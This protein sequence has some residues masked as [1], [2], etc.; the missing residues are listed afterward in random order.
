MKE[1]LYVSTDGYNRVFLVSDGIK[2][3]LKIDIKHSLK[4]INLGIKAFQKCRNKQ[5]GDKIVYRIS[6]EGLHALFPLF[7]KRKLRISQATFLYLTF[8]TNIKLE[9]LPSD[10]AELRSIASDTSLGY[11]ILY[12]EHD[13]IVLEMCT[14]LKFTSSIYFMASDDMITGLRIKYCDVYADTFKAKDSVDVDDMDK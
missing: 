2:E 6:Q 9:S 5:N 12:V 10:N 7:S 14:M 8:N 11:H 1:N 13:G 3:F 4:R